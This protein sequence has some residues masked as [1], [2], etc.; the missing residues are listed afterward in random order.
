MTTIRRLRAACLIVVAAAAA[1]PV[2]APSAGAADPGQQGP[3]TPGDEL[4][5]LSSVD[6]DVLL[7]ASSA[8]VVTSLDDMSSEVQDQVTAVLAARDAEAA[9]DAALEAA[10]AK[11]AETQAL[12]DDLTAQSDE[13][14]IESFVNPPSESAM[15]ALNAASP[16]DATVKQSI[17]KSQTAANV[18]V[19]SR[20]EQAQDD[21]AAVKA[22]QADAATAAEDRAAEARQALEDLVAGQSQE[23]LFVLAVQDRL[24]ENLAEAEAVE[25]VD[26]AAAEEIRAREAE[27]AAK[28]NE[29]VAD[30]EQR[31]AEAALRQAMADAAARAAEEAASAPPAGG[32]SLGP[33]TGSLSNVSCP[34]GGSITVDS[35][36]AG[37]LQS[38]LDAASADGINL[39][40]GGY[41]DPA[42]QIA[43]RKANCG[44]SYYAIYEA[45][46]SYCSPPTARPGTSM[47]EQGLAIDFTSGGGTIGS[48]SSAFSWLSAHASGY[49]LYNLPSEPWHWSTDGT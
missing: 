3:T 20:L 10:D 27:I 8:D 21:L 39:C 33:A 32:T 13:V 46:S 34:G 2:L 14:V 38:L 4:G 7:R 6:E 16:T 17:L 9:A 18:D 45:P 43:V 26:P 28:L 35:S 47:H 5:P 23:S 24:A 44:T 30:R 48:G 1:A 12:I 25:H 19:L 49:G 42:E 37:N 36:L 22:E 15:D 31:T 29:I 41:R 40:G 11:V